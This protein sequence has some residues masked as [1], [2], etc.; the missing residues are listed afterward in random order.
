MPRSSA[1][2]CYCEMFVTW[3]STLAAP[4]SLWRFYFS[5]IDLS[6]CSVVAA[7]WSC[8]C[9]LCS[10]SPFGS[11]F[12]FM[13]RLKN[14]VLFLFCSSFFTLL[15]IHPS[16]NVDLSLNGLFSSMVS[17]FPD[18]SLLLLSYP[19]LDW[20]SL[21]LSSCVAESSEKLWFKLF[22]DAELL[23]CADT[24]RFCIL[25]G[26]YNSL[27]G[28]FSISWMNLCFLLWFWESL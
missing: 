16:S 2:L 6:C 4:S 23:D 22:L 20:N 3:H 19:S 24:S 27:F 5:C 21:L 7:Y 12:R 8:Y 9:C 11:W 10:F 26:R 1:S 17:P 18:P 13:N 28:S 14:P 25:L 15:S